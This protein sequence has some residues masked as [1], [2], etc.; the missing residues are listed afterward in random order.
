MK[1]KKLFGWSLFILAPIFGLAEIGFWTIGI[2]LGSAPDLPSGNYGYWILLAVVSLLIITIISMFGGWYMAHPDKVG[3][4]RKP[5]G[6]I[7]LFLGFIRI[8]YFIYWLYQ[9]AGEHLI[10]G[11]CFLC[12][13]YNCAVFSSGLLLV[14][15]RFEKELNTPVTD[16]LPD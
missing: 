15:A 11:A 1:R 13:L 6:W 14:L 16:E 5:L 10:F 3:N 12:F 2:L 4:I 8:S 7:M 9:S